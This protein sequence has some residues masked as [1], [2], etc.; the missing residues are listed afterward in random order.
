MI[1][2]SQVFSSGSGV[3][4]AM[5]EVLDDLTIVRI[6]KIGER[7]WNYTRK[8]ADWDDRDERLCPEFCKLMGWA[9]DSN[10]Y[11]VFV[12]SPS[13]R[14]ERLCK[15]RTVRELAKE[16]RQSEPISFRAS[17]LELGVSPLRHLH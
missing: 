6:R 2:R 4:E 12:L 15:V 8:G 11:G 17:R 16:I 10:L 5:T 14:F 7:K 13:K 3:N 1:V 9:A